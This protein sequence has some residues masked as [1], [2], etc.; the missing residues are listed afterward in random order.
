MIPSMGRV[1]HYKRYDD[2]PALPAII[3]K[4]EGG[5]AYKTDYVLHLDVFTRE[6]LEFFTSESMAA[7]PGEAKAGQWWWPERV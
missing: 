1:V 6:G 3:L 4:V 7:G 2:Q 5:P